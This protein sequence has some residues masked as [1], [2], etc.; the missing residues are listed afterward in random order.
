LVLEA[1]GQAGGWL[2]LLSTDLRRYGALVSIGGFEV[3]SPVHPGDR[4]ELE[5]TLDSAGDE[6]WVMSGRALVGSRPVLAARE[7]MCVLVDAR[8]LEDIGSLRRRRSLVLGVP[9]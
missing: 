2:L 7:L 6:T 4:L 8:E 5:G 3:L 1:L 9:G